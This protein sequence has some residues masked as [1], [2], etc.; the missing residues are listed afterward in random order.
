MKKVWTKTLTI[1]A[2]ALSLVLAGCG[3]KAETSNANANVTEKKEI[4]IGT[5]PGMFADM[6]RE[7]VRPQLETKG[8]TVKLIEFT[9][10]VRPNHA[11]ADGDLDINVFQ[12]K[13]YL[14]LFKQQHDLDLVEFF[15]V[16]TSPLGIYTGKLTQLEDVQD[17]SSVSV[18]NDPSNFAR[19]LVMLDELGWIKLKEGIDPLVAT[20]KDIVENPKNI[21]IV[22]LEA[23]QLPRSRSDV[24]FAVINGNYAIDAG[25]KLTDALFQEPSFVYVNWSAIKPQDK[26]SQ[27]A[28]DVNDAYNSDEFKA[29]IHQKFPGFKLPAIWGAQ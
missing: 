25:F 18:A 22:E 13:P 20:K 19:A 2:L 10:Y 4:T 1:G 5:T 17:G 21:K 26:D 28:K 16:P 24:D 23:A 9:D 6:V 11:L 12:H 15:Q 3:E 14:D 7:S 29:Y 27:W 8:Y